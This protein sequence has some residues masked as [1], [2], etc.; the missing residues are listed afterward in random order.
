MSFFDVLSQE[1]SEQVYLLLTESVEKNE[2]WRYC[3][4]KHTT[5]EINKTKKKILQI[6]DVSTSVMYDQ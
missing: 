1:N 3:R 5:F 4:M 6:I 2:E